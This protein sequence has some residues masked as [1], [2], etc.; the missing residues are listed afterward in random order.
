VLTGLRVTN[1][2]EAHYAALAL[3]GRGANTA[4]ITMSGAGV[5]YVSA[6]SSGHIPAV[7]IDVVD[8]AGAGDALTA[9]VI[10]GL[11]NDFALDE[12][13]KLGT[14]MASLTMLTSETVHPELTL[15]RA[16]AHLE[17]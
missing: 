9:G 17:V 13:V 8:A 11:L 3:Q 7:T 4:I 10:F 2:D 6:D 5:V 15:E 14:A 12:A 1:R 16:Y